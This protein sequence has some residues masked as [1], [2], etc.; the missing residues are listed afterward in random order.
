[1]VSL[2]L[3]NLSNTN[4]SI[5]IQYGFSVKNKIGKVVKDFVSKSADGK[6]FGPKVM[7][8]GFGGRRIS[9]SGQK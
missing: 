3:Q 5:T 8:N 2:Y 1:M 6:E 9:G 7:T 4:T